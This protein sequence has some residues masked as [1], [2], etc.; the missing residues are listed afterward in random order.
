MPV[1]AFTAALGAARL[2]TRVA[3]AGI[4][5]WAPV[6]FGALAAALLAQDVRAARDILGRVAA[7]PRAF[8]EAVAMLPQRPNIVFVRYAARRSMHIAL[9][10]NRGMLGAAPSWIVHDRG[11]DNARL[12]AASPGRAAYLFDEASGEFREVRR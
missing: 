10:A 4:P 9:V 6:A 11:A 12:L 1:L 7:T 5:R 3:R 2:A 8:R